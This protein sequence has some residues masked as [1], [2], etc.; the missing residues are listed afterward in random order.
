VDG[1]KQAITA[2]VTAD[3]DAAVAD[4]RLTEARKQE[5]LEDLA[6]RVDDLVA[7]TGLPGP[8][9][10]GFR[11]GFDRGFPE[12]GPPADATELAPATF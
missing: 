3:L 7:R 9:G 12:D 11:G 4:G 2:D 5:V 6:A 1:L 8:P 10:H